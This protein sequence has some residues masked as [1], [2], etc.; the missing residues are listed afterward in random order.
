M[1]HYL[2]PDPLSAQQLKRLEEHKYSAS[3]RSLFEPPCQIYWNWLVQKI[4]TW[5]APNT[6]TI[7]GLIVNIVTTVILVY[8][9]PS[10]TEE[11]P[12]WAFILSALGLFIYQSLDA[13][14]GKQARRTN[15]SSALGELFDHGCDA[16]STVFV[17][18]GTCISCGMGAYSNWMFFSGFVGMFMFFCAHWQTYVSGTL[19]FGLVDVTE[20]Q[21]A[22]MV[23]Y[24]MTAFGGVSLWESRLPV[25]GIKLNTFP[26]L[27]IIGGAL[28]SCS[29]YFQVIMNGGVGKNGS[30]V[31]DT[32]VLSPG[33]HIGLILTLA[34]I[35]FKK[36]SSQLFEL[37]PC[38]YI[39]TFGIVMAKIS[40][41]LVVAHM[42]KSEL[43]LQDTAFIGPGL[44]FLN[45][46]FNS[47]IDEYFV[48]WTALLLSLVDLARYCT[49]VCLQIAG[50]LKIH[51]FSITAQV[52]AHRD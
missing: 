21:I 38:L 22:I 42:T 52:G 4:P 12:A 32:S 25:L 14:D 44:L 33:M 41:K 34:F 47:F 37:H 35:I 5:V 26:V 15:S 27:G 50:H 23:M 10:A 19:R 30:T 16:V 49:G 18:V 39:L 7:T 9:C 28:F 29:N 17:A 20:V 40:N 31:A 43:H 51:V 2:W 24:L 36:S 1:T 48:L 46:Y 8:Y 11:A 13:I 6:L 3:G 45:Q